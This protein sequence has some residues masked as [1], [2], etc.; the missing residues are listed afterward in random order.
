[1]LDDHTLIVL[2]ATGDLTGRLLLPAL[3]RL[4]KAGDLGAGFRFVGAGPQTLDRNTFRDHART[5]LAEHAA[6]LTME[7]REIVVGRLEYQRVDVTDAAAVVNL[8]DR[9]GRDATT[10]Y[11]A[12]P[13]RLLAVTVAALVGQPVAR[14]I[15]IAVE[16]P[17]GEDWQGAVRLNEDL[18]RAVGSPDRIFR[19]DHVLGMDVVARL[20]STLAQLQSAD[21][22]AEPNIEEVS[23]LWE[24]TLALEGRAA[25]Y[26]GAGALKDL[27]QNH[28]LQILCMVTMPSGPDAGGSDLPRRR[29]EA[30][31][32]IGVPTPSQV[33]A[34]SRRARYV[35]GQLATTGGAHGDLV[36]DYAHEVGVDAARNTETLAEVALDVT[37]PPWVHTRFVLRAGKA[38]RHRRRGVLVRYRPDANGETAAQVWIDVDQPVTAT[39][40]GPGE[41]SS[42]DSS[43]LEQTAYANV[44]RG[45]LAGSHEISVS[46]EETELAW[47][48]F[49]PVVHAW[50]EGLV[51]LEQYAAG[52]GLLP[53]A[54]RSSAHQHGRAMR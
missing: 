11:L 30:L 53:R 41:R 51:P 36:P 32:D 28:L 47:R 31:R 26:D 45:L 38:M 39:A 22:S 35:S 20:P 29:L 43:L 19:I 40:D 15:Q 42:G 27:L 17:F 33:Q 24:E 49:N 7:E 52:T 14:T 10:L 9:W 6:D 8:L 21:S 3:A 44:L 4:G 18:T 46:A 16:K 23:I 13:T 34:T 37:V 25:F 12:L 1:M 48:I 54:A 50:T 2:G 5:R